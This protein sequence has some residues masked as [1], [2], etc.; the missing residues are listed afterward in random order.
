MSTPLQTQSQKQY[1]FT[2]SVQI[3]DETGHTREV[4][5]VSEYP[6][7]IKVNDRERQTAFVT[8]RDGQPTD[9]VSKIG[10]RMVT[11]GCGEGTIF[12]CTLEKIYEKRLAPQ[13]IRA[14][15]IYDLL[16]AVKG[17]S[18]IYALAGSVHTCAKCRPPDAEELQTQNL[19]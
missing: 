5:V 8:P 1:P 11:S 16:H 3:T 18:R 13:S 17:Y 7:T 6:L 10:R 12:S 4:D 9:W 2:H 15:H 14:A 19:I